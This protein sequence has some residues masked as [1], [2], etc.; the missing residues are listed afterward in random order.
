M[1]KE[2]GEGKRWDWLPSQMP[3]VTQLMASQRQALGADWVAECWRHG[4]QGLQPGWFYA[5]EG[6]LT[7]GT[8]WE[9]TRELE[10]ECE[11]RAGTYAAVV[12][13]MLKPKENTPHGTN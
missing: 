1:K 3:K 13:V 4:V 11:A 10:R 9:S 2:G 5:R 12:F 6:A 8:P 7:V